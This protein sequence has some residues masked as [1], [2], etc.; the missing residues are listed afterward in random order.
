MLVLILAAGSFLMFVAILACLF[1]AHT[2]ESREITRKRNLW[3]QSHVRLLSITQAFEPIYA[4]LWEAPIAAL[5]VVNSAKWGTPA[6]RLEPIYRQASTAFPEIYDGCEFV[7]WL[8]FLE[9]EDLVGW[10]PEKNR[11]TITEKGKEF[12]ANRFVRDALLEA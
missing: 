12:L 1:I 8:Q 6:G 3:T 2:L 11:V 10:H 9:G 5:Q 4:P 7:Q